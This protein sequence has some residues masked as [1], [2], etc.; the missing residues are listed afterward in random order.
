[1]AVLCEVC[2]VRRSG[3]DA[4]LQRQASPTMPRDDLEVVAQVQAIAGATGHRD[5]SRRMAKPRQA[6]GCAVGRY[7]ALP[8]MR[9]AG[10]VG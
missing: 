10:L 9:Q 4:S 5:G 7:T 1:M 8:L 3:F 2:E 6:A